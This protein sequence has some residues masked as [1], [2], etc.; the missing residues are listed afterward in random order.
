MASVVHDNV[1][2][3][4]EFRDKLAEALEQRYVSEVQ[5]EHVKSRAPVR[6]ILLLQEALSRVHGKSS[7]DNEAGAASQQLEAALV[8]DL[9]PAAGDEGAPGAHEFGG[10]RGR[11]GGLCRHAYMPLRSAVSCLFDQ[12]NNAQSGQRWL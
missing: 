3:R 4:I 1:N 12:L 8:A 9:L 10:R 11:A 2:G 5:A 7:R 6:A